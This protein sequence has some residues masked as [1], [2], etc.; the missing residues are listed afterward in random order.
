MS[1]ENMSSSYLFYYEIEYKLLNKKNLNIIT[2]KN[3]SN[4]MLIYIYISIEKC[5]ILS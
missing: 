2:I 4:K 1:C 3:Q 5:Y